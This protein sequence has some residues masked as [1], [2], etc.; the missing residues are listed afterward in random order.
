MTGPNLGK[1][2][3]GFGP[4]KSHIFTI[5]VAVRLIC[6]LFLF[7][8]VPMDSAHRDTASAKFIRPSCTRENIMFCFPVPFWPI[9]QNLGI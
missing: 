1:K 9:C 3:S 2:I 8:E 6:Y 4:Q 7:I 5:F